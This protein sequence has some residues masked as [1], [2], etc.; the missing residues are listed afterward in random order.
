M[1]VLPGDTLPSLACVLFNIHRLLLNQGLKRLESHAD[2]ILANLG[3]ID[4]MLESVL[5]DASDCPRLFVLTPLKGEHSVGH[6]FSAD[7]Q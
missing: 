1:N 2:D 4:R 3:R 6:R 7:V 5:E